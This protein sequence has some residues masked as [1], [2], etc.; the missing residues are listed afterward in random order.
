MK[1][2]LASDLH[3]EFIARQ[4]PGETLIRPAYGADVLVLAGDIANDLLAIKLFAHWPVPVVYVP[5]NHEYYNTDWP[6]MREQLQ[7]G[8]RGTS[9]TVLDNC[10]WEDRGV[11]F[12]GST[13]W[14]DYRLRANRTQRH[15]WT[16]RAPGFATTLRFVLVPRR[17]RRKWRC[18]TTSTRGAG[19][20]TNS[21]CPMRA[22]RWSTHHGP[23][24]QSV[25]PRY[26]GDP[27]NAAFVSE[28][29]DEVVGRADFWLHGH[30]HDS[31]DYGVGGCR[32]VAN[33][34]GYPRNRNSVDSVKQLEFENPA[35]QW[36]C[37]IDV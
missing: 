7:R 33:P 16:W 29:D 32:V 5:G 12:L 6:T 13:L 4:F 10:T 34:R 20:R 15:S 31:F 28:L 8:A 37:L 17:S 36:V 25:H 24:A 30:V 27:L 35:F 19:W 22:R 1:I 11:R 21:P 26:L 2:Q 18:G 23:S 3:L 9:V 14:T